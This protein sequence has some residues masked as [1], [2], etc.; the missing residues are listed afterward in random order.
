MLALLLLLTDFVRLSFHFFAKNC[1]GAKAEKRT[2][3]VRYQS[4]IFTLFDSEQMCASQPL[5]IPSHRY[6]SR[7]SFSCLAPSWM[8]FLCLDTLFTNARVQQKEENTATSTIFVQTKKIKWKSH[9]GIHTYSGSIKKPST[10]LLITHIECYPWTVDGTSSSL[11]PPRTGEKTQ[12]IL[13]NTSFV[14]T[15][16]E[17]TKENIKFRAFISISIVP[18]LWTQT[19]TSW[20]GFLSKDSVKEDLIPTCKSLNAKH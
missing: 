18:Y 8:P 20:S 11:F 7:S 5:L 12:Q 19:R 10:I 14:T 2:L 1:G 4:G 9:N 3:L 15:F 6:F 17:K 16:W 13:V